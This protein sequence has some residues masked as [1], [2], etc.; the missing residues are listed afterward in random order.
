MDATQ[1]I[2]GALGIAL[3]PIANAMQIQQQKRLQGLQIEGQKEMANYNK[4]IAIEMQDRANKYNSPEE[5]RKRLQQ[6]GLNIGLMYGQSGAGGTTT[7]APTNSGN[8]NGANAENNITANAAMGIQFGLQAKLQEAQ[9]KNIEAD[10]QQKQIESAKTAGVD[11]QQT[12]ATIENIKQETKNKQSQ[13]ALIEVQ[14]A[15]T[16]LQQNILHKTTNDIIKTASANLEK[17]QAEGRSAIQAAQYDEN[18]RQE[19]EKQLNQYTTEQAIRIAL[20]KTQIQ[21]TESEIQKMANEIITSKGHLSNDTIKTEFQTNTPA[22]IKQYT[23]ILT[24]ILYSIH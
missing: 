14:T 16:D 1:A 12:T 15:L 19:R 6:A 20:T 13:Q 8:V 3:T 7:T 9:I 24:S 22:Q 23:D 17:L 18:T 21:K 2:G 5:Q 4:N 11:T 10:T